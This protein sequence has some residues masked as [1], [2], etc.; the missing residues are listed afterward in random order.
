[1]TLEENIK[2]ILECNFSIAREEVIESA[3]KRIMEQ[4]SRQNPLEDI[5]AEIENIDLVYEKNG[6][7][8]IMKNFDDIKSEIFD[9][10]DKHI[11]KLKGEDSATM[12]NIIDRRIC[13]LKNEEYRPYL[14]R[15]IET[16][17]KGESD[18]NNKT[19]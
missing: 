17:L 13:E 5:K 15:I 19:D 2:A 18:A 4:I 7:A 10:L 6:R 16:E 1:M 14:E 9:I 11:S 3:T 8:T 12:I